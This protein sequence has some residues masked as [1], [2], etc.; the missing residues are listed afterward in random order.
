MHHSWITPKQNVLIKIIYMDSKNNQTVKAFEE[1]QK[2]Y[3]IKPI[4]SVSGM[5]TSFEEQPNIVYGLLVPSS[6]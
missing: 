4:M 5:L 6:S 3:L 1:H 2:E